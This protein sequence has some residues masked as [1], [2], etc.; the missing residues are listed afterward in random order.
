M[1][2]TVLHALNRFTRPIN[3]ILRVIFPRFLHGY[4]QALFHAL[5]RYTAPKI[6]DLQL[7]F[8]TQSSSIIFFF[9]TYPDETMKIKHLSYIIYLT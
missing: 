4:I 7:A 9:T 2:V 6:L 5:T 8:E 1:V 3:L